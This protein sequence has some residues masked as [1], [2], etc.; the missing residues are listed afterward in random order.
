MF[1]LFFINKN[2]KQLK[3]D[4]SQEEM[5]E[6][7]NNYLQYKYNNYSLKSFEYLFIQSFSHYKTFNLKDIQ[8][9][10]SIYF[11]YYFFKSDL[12]K[13][14]LINLCSK[15]QN[16]TNYKL[17][18]LNWKKYFQSKEL[19]IRCFSETIKPKK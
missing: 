12:L 3:L 6:Q 14:L 8:K 18:N 2:L 4:C 10:V 5:N 11:D 16:K 17:K 15:L 1:N 7:N 19:D 13:H 9:F